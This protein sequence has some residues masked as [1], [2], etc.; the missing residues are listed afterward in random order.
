MS[1]D[2]TEEPP[3]AD[4]PPDDGEI[5]DVSTFEGLQKAAKSRRRKGNKSRDFWRAVLSTPVGRA[6]I[7]ALL[8]DAGTFGARFGVGP[9]GFPND[10]QTWFNAGQQEFGQRW[11]QFLLVIDLEGVRKMLAENDSR[12]KAE[13][14]RNDST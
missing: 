1:G 14:K 7:W 9:N 5:V 11:Y 8:N 2:G 4:V 10:H 6:E 3:R 12:F 13:V